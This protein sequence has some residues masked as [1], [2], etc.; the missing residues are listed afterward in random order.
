MAD[1]WLGNRWLTR[2]EIKYHLDFMGARTASLTLLM[3][4]QG[5]STEIL[6][7]PFIICV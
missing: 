1:D 3:Y 7:V 2:R 6:Q 5:A 4:F